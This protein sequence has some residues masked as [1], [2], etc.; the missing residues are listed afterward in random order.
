VNFT[1]CLH[2]YGISLV[3]FAQGNNWSNTMS[4]IKRTYAIPSDLLERFE[5]HVVT[6]QRS[7]VIAAL[8]EEWLEERK[9][10]ALRHAII[11]GCRD[12]AEADLEIEAEWNPL[13]EEVWRAAS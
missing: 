10:E 11:E 3:E 1:V 8:I 2:Q 13:E 12:M 6:G 9:R 5:E 7:H 4:T